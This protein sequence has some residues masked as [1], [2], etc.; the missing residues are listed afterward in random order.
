MRKIIILAFIL[1]IGMESALAATEI[2]QC[3]DRN[4]AEL[5]ASLDIRR[6]DYGLNDTAGI[7]YSSADGALTFC[8][9][10]SGKIY[11]IEI[12]SGGSAFSIMGVS[13][14]M[15]AK[16]ALK[17][18]KAALEK[19]AASATLVENSGESASVN[20]DIGKD[21]PLNFMIDF[22]ASKCVSHILLTWSDK[23][24]A[25]SPMP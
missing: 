18:F 3:I 22:D 24:V 16:P 20:I 13:P 17:A 15:K 5:P 1:L 11:M 21:K 10:M 9:E 8:T 12:S 23:T 6:N 4:I 2:A 14:G 7:T 19:I 25:L